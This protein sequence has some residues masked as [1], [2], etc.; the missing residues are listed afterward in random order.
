MQAGNGVEVASDL[1]LYLLSYIFYW[2]KVVENLLR[3]FATD[4]TDYID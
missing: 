3:Y 1:S 4:Y 2:I